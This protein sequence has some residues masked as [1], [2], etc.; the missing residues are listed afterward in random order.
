MLMGEYTDMGRRTTE[1]R[2]II[3]CEH[4]KMVQQWQTLEN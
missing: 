3:K 2:N 1:Y 4:G